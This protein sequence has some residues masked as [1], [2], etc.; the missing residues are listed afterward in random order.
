MQS[1]ADIAAASAAALARSYPDTVE[2]THIKVMI[3]RLR[4]PPT[5]GGKES[6]APASASDVEGTLADGDTGQIQG[7]E[8]EKQQDATAD[9]DSAAS[10]KQSSTA[11]SGPPRAPKFV[12]VPKEVCSCVRMLV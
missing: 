8:N 12:Q 7:S 2:V 6:A 1:A 4:E 10:N 5:R 3:R 11:A 9:K